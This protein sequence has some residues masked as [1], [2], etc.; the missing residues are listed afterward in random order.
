MQTQNPYEILDTTSPET[1][2]D[3]TPPTETTTTWW[4]DTQGKKSSPSLGFIDKVVRFIAKATGNPDPLTWKAFEKTEKTPE[5]HNTATVSSGSAK[6]VL[7]GMENFLA[8]IW[9][10]LEH[11][12]DKITATAKETLSKGKNEAV[13]DTS[14]KKE[15]EQEEIPSL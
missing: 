5:S 7:A 3:P 1:P 14:N 12:A 4:E 13:T 8:G 10:S 11:T 2:K 9:N 6:E 15:S